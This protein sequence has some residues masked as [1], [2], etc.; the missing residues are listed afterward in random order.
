MRKTRPLALA[1]AIAVCVAAMTAAA[2]PVPV[3]APKPAPN[4]SAPTP[5]VSTDA[6]KPTPPLA[7]GPQS[8]PN[9]AAPSHPQEAIAAPGGAVAFNAK[10]RALIERANTY[11]AGVQTL[12]GDFVQVAA[13]GARSE[14]KFY[15]QKPGRLRFEYD[16]P[17]T[18]ELIADGETVAIRDSRLNNQTYLPQSQT[19]LRFLFADR[20][21]LL[22]D[23]NVIAAYSDDMFAT[24]VIEEHQTFA[25]T[26]RLMLMFGARDFQLRQWTVTDP[27]GFDTTV[28]VYNLDKSK[29]VDPS[30]FKIDYERMLQ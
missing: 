12:V 3:P 7:L 27:Q 11:F 4:R 26:Q 5:G 19:P 21:D 25:G 8:L 15:L 13:N 28:A 30:L 29:K 18:V 16:P 20:V 2:Q 10:Q 6:N 1:G 23:T 22:K 9:P 17:S 14:G 24:V